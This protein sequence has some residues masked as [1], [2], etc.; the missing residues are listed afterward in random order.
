MES[1]NVILLKKNLK[2][3]NEIGKDVWISNKYTHWI[4]LGHFDDIYIYS[5]N[6]E[7]DFF[8]RIKEDKNRV[9]EHNSDYAY[10]HPLYLVPDN[11]STVS[12]ENNFIAIVRIHFPQSL[13]LTTQFKKI[14][15]ALVKKMQCHNL[16]YQIYYATEFSDMVLDVRS[17]QLNSLLEVVLRFREIEDINIGKMYTYFGINSNYLQSSV[18]SPDENDKIPMF[19][20]RFSGYNM[21]IAKKQI[22]FI[23]RFLEREKDTEPAE[24][25]INGIDDIML[26]YRNRSTSD[27][28]KLY[29]SWLYNDDYKMYR[30]SESFTRVGVEINVESTNFQS[31]NPDE[32]L[33][34][35]PVCSDLP[36]LCDK[37]SKLIST[38]S[39]INYYGWFHTIS[40]VSNSLVRMSKTPIMDEIVF[41][42]APGVRAFLINVLDL[43]ERKQ[44]DCFSNCSYLYDYVESCSYYIEQ[45]M[46]IE[47]QLSHNPEI[48]PVIYDIPVFMLEY[49]IAFLNK[50]SKLLQY[51]D[52]DNNQRHTVFLL[53]PRPCER[54]SALE[55]FPVKNDIPGLVHIRIPE[56]MLYTPTETFRSLCHEISHYVGEKYRNRNKRKEAYSQALAAFLIDSVYQS[57]DECFLEMFKELFLNSLKNK[58]EPTIREMHS[59]ILISA[60]D[61]LFKEDSM[62]ALMKRYFAFADSK[63]KIPSHINF[64]ND[65]EIQ[66][67]FYHAFECYVEDIDVL[68]REVF[69]DICMLHILN[70]DRDNY[71][72]SLLQEI[73]NHPE[74]NNISDEMF[75]IRIYATL[76]AIKKDI[77]YDGNAYRSDWNKIEKIINE[78]KKDIDNNVDGMVEL[79]IPSSAIYALTMYA[80]E[81]YKTMSTSLL[82]ANLIEV[83]QMYSSLLSDDFQ[84]Y[85]ILREIE[86]CRE[87][88]LQ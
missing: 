36:K 32:E 1:L 56:N 57:K 64:L 54:A 9:F 60:K 86:E 84:Y 59:S 76:T 26:I 41:L 14:R 67:F 53:V 45:L 71:I 13:R 39:N 18:E 85:N 50:I 38:R 22:D 27:L 65:D 17:N 8:S 47:G 3:I 43:M 82:R 12:N 70:L 29:R 49:T 5:L 61:I 55:I 62:H 77:K 63:S 46:R 88:M 68:F 75:A 16:S 21:E 58:E 6:N 72:F 34:N 69:A 30:K 24:Y 35:S 37:I 42:I 28:I 10:Y 15:D 79:P 87:N 33:I 23:K 74:P 81:C 7:K 2:P 44:D 78:I 48:R 40:E 19:S 80:E 66:F 31:F 51:N 83:N 25:C 11:T 4:A 20:M 52:P 73:A